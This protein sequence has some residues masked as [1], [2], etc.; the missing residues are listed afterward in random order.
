MDLEAQ[1]EVADK[2]CTKPEESFMIYK[3]LIEQVLIQN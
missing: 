3:V 2:E 1:I